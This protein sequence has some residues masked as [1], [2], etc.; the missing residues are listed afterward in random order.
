MTK[1]GLPM[2]QEPWYGE[3]LRFEC[4]E[5]GK[6][7]TGEPGAVWVNDEEIASM[8]EVLEISVKQFRWRYLDR[9]A[10]RWTLKE[11]PTNYDC[12]FLKG[13]LCMIYKSRPTQCRTFPW[14]P[15]VIESEASWKDAAKTCEGINDEAPIVPRH[16]IESEL[17]K[18]YDSGHA[19][20]H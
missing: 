11:D 10:G 8:A 9:V 15:G 16:K 18:M 7:C 2:A 13:K 20:R 17:E 3:G 6:C 14:W 12:I 19:D 1:E 5:C 4:T